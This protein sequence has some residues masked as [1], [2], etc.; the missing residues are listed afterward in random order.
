MLT[1]VC[2]IMVEIQVCLFLL[3]KSH[4]DTGVPPVSGIFSVGLQVILVQDIR[5]ARMPPR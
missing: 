2:S 3:W 4:E 1:F 5:R